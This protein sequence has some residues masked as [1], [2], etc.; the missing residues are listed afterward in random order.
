MS[1]D[2][3]DLLPT[4]LLGFSSLFPLINPIGTAFII[5]PYFSNL[6]DAARRR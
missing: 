4:F 1:T 5:Q 2:L 6:D 3:S